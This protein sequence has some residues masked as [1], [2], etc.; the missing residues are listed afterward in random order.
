[1]IQWQ[2]SKL[3]VRTQDLRKS[4]VYLSAIM[5][6]TAAQEDPR[7]ILVRFIDGLPKGQVIRVG[8][9]R[10]DKSHPDTRLK[11]KGSSRSGGDSSPT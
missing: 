11:E 2:G 6:P 3:S 1:M 10:V 7:D 4:L 5:L 8:W 9:V